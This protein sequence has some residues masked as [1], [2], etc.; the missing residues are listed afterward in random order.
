MTE[1]PNTT[2]TIKKTNNN[3]TYIWRDDIYRREPQVD[4]ICAMLVMVNKRVCNIQ[5]WVGIF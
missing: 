1:L 4:F 2:T 5:K 3:R